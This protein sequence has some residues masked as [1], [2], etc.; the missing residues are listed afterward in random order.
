MLDTPMPRVWRAALLAMALVVLG[1]SRAA[2][3]PDA[4]AC[5]QQ[6]GNRFF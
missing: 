2:A 5:N 3:Q 6:P 1:A 4:L